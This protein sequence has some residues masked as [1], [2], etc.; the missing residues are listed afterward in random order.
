VLAVAAQAATVTW[1]GTPVSGNWSV[2][3]NWVGG[4]SNPGETT[5]FPQNQKGEL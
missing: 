5:F 4:A 2:G 3:A 1:S